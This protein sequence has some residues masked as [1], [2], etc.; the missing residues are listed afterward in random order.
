MTSNKFLEQS[1]QT[2]SLRLTCSW[3]GRIDSQPFLLPQ[4]R[5]PFKRS[6][7]WC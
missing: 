5:L 3:S 6:S 4:A 1:A 7:T 2:R